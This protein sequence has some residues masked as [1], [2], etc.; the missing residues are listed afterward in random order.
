M[1]REPG[2]LVAQLPAA[3]D[4]VER[5]CVS[6]QLYHT[7]GP[8]RQHDTHS[9]KPST[10]AG[11]EVTSLRRPLIR[12]E[13][14]GMLDDTIVVWERV[15]PHADGRTARLLARPSRDGYTMWRLAVASAENHRTTESSGYYAVDDRV[16][17]QIL[18]ARS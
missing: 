15:R 17:V 7:T 10:I 18:Q 5:A 12:P 9:G 14:R 6:I 4:L 2:N 8:P 3:G 1:A 13:E 11:K 16:H